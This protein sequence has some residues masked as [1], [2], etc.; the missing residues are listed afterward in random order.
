VTGGPRGARLR[1][2]VDVFRVAA[3]AYAVA[4]HVGAHDEYRH[5]WGGWAVLTLLALWTAFLVAPRDGAPRWTR[6]YAR[7]WIGWADLAI[8][9]AAV[10]STRLFDEPG[11]IE[12]GAQTLPSIWPASA[13]LA[14]AV[15]RGWRGGLVAAAVVAV[16]DLAE[17]G[18]LG[19]P[20]ANTT[21]NNIILLFLAGLIVGYAAEVVRAGEADLAA[22]VAERAA[23]AERL[24][25]AG[26]IHDSVLQVLGYVHREG[27]RSEVAKAAGEAEAR[28]RALIAGRPAVPVG[29]GAVAGGSSQ[30]DLRAALDRFA[31]AA[32]T[33]VGPA[34]AVEAP[35]PVVDALT[36]A[37]GAALDNVRQHAGP[38]AKAWVL[39]EEEPGAV[40]VTVRD[41]GPGI[42][43]E[44]L[45]EA[46][47]QGRLGVSVSI[48]GRVEQVGGTVN[49][50]STPGQGTEIEMSVP[51]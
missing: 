29:P 46:R 38:A 5:P 10:L 22:A 12:A 21:A 6:G 31:A 14:W 2:V 8:A 19:T 28:L 48:R 50:V 32:V 47:A 43:A 11:R 51:R 40:T 37:V 49:I 9:A 13:V 30:P 7:S 44:R 33:I 24:R 45:E 15:A 26:D 17:L 4:L 1:R 23:T 27:G 39:L 41:D 3:L 34:H 18:R 20:A 42:P 25:L 35:G 16:A 36:G